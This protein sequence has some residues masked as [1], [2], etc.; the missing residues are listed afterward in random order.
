LE[1]ESFPVSKPLFFYRLVTAANAIFSD[2]PYSVF[3]FEYKSRKA[4]KT[5]WCRM[6]A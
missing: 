1:K 4:L 5:A 3:H 6:V 2:F